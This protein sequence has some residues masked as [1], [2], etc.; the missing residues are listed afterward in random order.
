[1][2]GRI[3]CSDQIF[4][5]VGLPFGRKTWSAVVACFPPTTPAAAPWEEVLKYHKTKVQ[6]IP[7]DKNALNPTIKGILSFGISIFY[8]CFIKQF[9]SLFFAYSTISKLKS[10]KD[11][12]V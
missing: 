9:N 2:S 10:N 12:T 4:A 5:F 7:K 11:S 1:V 6:D 3:G 8:F